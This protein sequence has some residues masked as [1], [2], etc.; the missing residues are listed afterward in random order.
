MS[1][2]K[3]YAVHR[4]HQTGIFTDWNVVKPLVTG[5]PN[6][7]YKSFKTLQQATYFLTYGSDQPVFQPVF[8]PPIQ[9][10]TQVNQSTTQANQSSIQANQSTTQANQSSIQSSTQSSIQPSTLPNDQSSDESFDQILSS[11]AKLKLEL[12][13]ILTQ[14]N[15]FVIYTD[16]S[17]TDNRGGYAFL[18]LKVQ[19]GNQV[20]FVY[21]EA[22]PY[23]VEQ[24][25]KAAT[26]QR[27][28][29]LAILKSFQYINSNA[30]QLHLFA[31]T[32]SIESTEHTEHT[33]HTK[34]SIS[35]FEIRSDSMYSIKSLTEW[36]ANW[37]RSGWKTA[38]GTP[39]EN[40]DLI[41]PILTIYNQLISNYH[42]EVNFLHVRAH[43]GEMYNE[44]VDKLANQGRLMI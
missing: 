17:Y 8:Q 9:P 26:N 13:V 2:T 16:G 31:K 41:E 25:E 7:R 3:Y 21:Q 27:A 12:D 15:R 10:S 43:Q 35:N 20:I 44:H 33:E 40:R 36:A 28:E 37:I 39:V 11:L 18:V 24:F 6:A 14:K 1:T 4:G 32:E 23:R 34:N 19:T 29:L 38:T 5:Y 22:G 30:T 42:V